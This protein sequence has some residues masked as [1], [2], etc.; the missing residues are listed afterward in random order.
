MN[1]SVNDQIKDDLEVLGIDDNQE[2]TSRYVTLKYKKLA[3]VLHPDK[4][5]GDKCAFQ[6]L[7][8]S[9][10]RIIKHMEE[11]MK[12]DEVPD[13]DFEKEFFMKHNIMKECISSYVVY[14]QE[15][16]ID[17]WKKVLESHMSIHKSDKCRIIFKTGDVTITLYEK[18][19]KDPRSKLHIQS[20][21]QEKNL[22]FIIDKLSMFYR[23]VCKLNEVTMTSFEFKNIQRSIC[24]KC[25]KYFTNKKGVKQH[26]LRMHSSRKVLNKISRISVTEDEIDSQAT[27]KSLM[28]MCLANNIINQDVPKKPSSQC[29]DC[30]YRSDSID[31]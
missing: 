5:S 18:P 29:G 12:V 25:N 13:D 20:G 28:E 1:M 23:E 27:D 19:K 6:E 8:N 7:L 30:D 22:E 10:R 14:V 26:M 31:F 16:L 11:N 2:L 21:S 15:T 9:Y 24:G 4:K 3:K 17:K